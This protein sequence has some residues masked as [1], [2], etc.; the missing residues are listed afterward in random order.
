MRVMS[1]QKRQ[2]IA[3]SGELTN[4]DQSLMAYNI[5]EGLKDD[6][7]KVETEFLLV[8]RREAKDL[9]KQ[10]TT[11]VD[12]S[13]KTRLQKDIERVRNRWKEVLTLF[14][15]FKSVLNELV[16]SNQ[17]LDTL[18][19]PDQRK[20]IGPLSKLSVEWTKFF[21]KKDKGSYH[22]FHT[23]DGLADSL[24][25]LLAIQKNLQEKREVEKR[26]KGK[27]VGSFPEALKKAIQEYKRDKTGDPEYVQRVQRA[28]NSRR[29]LPK[30]G[31]RASV[32]ANMHVVANVYLWGRDLAKAEKVWKRA[33]LDYT[34]L[35]DTEGSSLGFVIFHNQWLLL[36]RQD[37][38]DEY[39]WNEEVIDV[40]MKL[41]G[42]ADLGNLAAMSLQEANVEGSKYYAYWMATRKQ[43]R[44]VGWFEEWSLPAW[45]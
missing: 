23:K 16:S 11:F 38:G 15:S 19:G 12:R 42:A 34:V 17:P 7:E 10:L 4:F 43:R 31:Q 28:K 45:K 27:D 41:T 22:E 21:S 36:I 14:L 32:A 8:E 33:K 44:R 37:L 39:S 26:M 9:T 30:D 25:R 3:V 35:R 1:P 20:I 18:S 29:A 40:A 24:E 2:F 6:P 5:L 13:E